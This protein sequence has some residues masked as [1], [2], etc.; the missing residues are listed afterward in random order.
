MRRRDLQ[1]YEQLLVDSGGS[2]EVEES[3][4]KMV[5]GDV[6]RAPSNP[7]ALCVHVGSGVQILASASI[8]L[9]FAALGF[10][11]PASRGS[12]AERAAR[13]AA[14]DVVLTSDPVSEEL[15]LLCGVP[16]VALGRPQDSLPARPQVKG[17][18]PAE[19][20]GSLSTDAVLAALGLG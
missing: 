2:A 17:L 5:S 20:L 16:L 1:R 3:G 11:S 15:A 6:F 12:L 8:T 14:S 4:W 19:G 18:D 10:L 13:I 9:V 7:L